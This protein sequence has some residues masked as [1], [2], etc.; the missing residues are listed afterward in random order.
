VLAAVAVLALLAVPQPAHAATA[1]DRC[2]ANAMCVFEHANGLGHYA[3]FYSGASNLTIPIG[4]FVF[5]DKITSIW[6][7]HPYGFC[8]NRDINW[9]T[10]LFVAVGRSRGVN[11]PT[12]YND[13]ISSLSYQHSLCTASTPRIP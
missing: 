4:G 1:W 13:V 5:N 6:N 2:P 3:Y 9:R 10:P 12:Q 8:V 11:L 7:R